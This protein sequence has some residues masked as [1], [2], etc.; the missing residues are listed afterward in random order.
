MGRLEETMAG[1]KGVVRVDRSS[2]L[3]GWLESAAVAAVGKL[4]TQIS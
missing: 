1:A 3:D 4:S 2:R